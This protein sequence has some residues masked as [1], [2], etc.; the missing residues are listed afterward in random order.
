[1][2]MTITAY[3]NTNV[4]KMRYIIGAFGLFAFL[5]SINLVDAQIIDIIPDEIRY[6]LIS[7]S[8]F[9]IL[10]LLFFGIIRK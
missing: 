7:S 10:I 4:R 3:R 2:A 1:M 6:T 9:I 8:I 5:A